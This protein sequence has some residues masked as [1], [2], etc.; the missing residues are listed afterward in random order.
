MGSHDGG[1]TPECLKA[2]CSAG[3]NLR[4]YVWTGDLDRK[5]IFERRARGEKLRTYLPT[6]AYEC[7]TCHRTY[8]HKVPWKFR[9]APA[10]FERTEAEKNIDDYIA[11]G[12]ASEEV[13]PNIPT[14]PVSITPAAPPESP[15]EP[16]KGLVAVNGDGEIDYAAPACPQCGDQWIQILNWLPA[17]T[18]RP[19]AEVRFACHHCDR[20]FLAY[21]PKN[22]HPP[23]G[24]LP[25]F[26]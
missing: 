8:H 21:A 19:K 1:R 26:A 20:T 5:N 3:T 22:W 13:T 25:A 12:Y 9:P 11:E 10:Y 24:W 2:N 15:A 7:L 16:A 23:H 18:K 6:V 14:G 4:I 17:N